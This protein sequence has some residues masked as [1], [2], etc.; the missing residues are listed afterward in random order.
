MGIHTAATALQQGD[1][2]EKQTSKQAKEQQQKP[3]NYISATSQ[4]VPTEEQT[5]T[6]L[7]FP[8]KKSTK[9][10]FHCFYIHFLR[11]SERK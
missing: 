9:K 8:L 10:H 1:M 7:K 2:A 3:T 6:C 11:V 4:G 5:E